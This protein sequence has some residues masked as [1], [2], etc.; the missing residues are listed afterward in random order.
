MKILCS[1]SGVEFTCEHFPGYLSSREYYHPIFSLPQRKL[2]PYLSKW[3]TSELTPTDS[4][5]LFLALLK[6][7]DLVEFRIPAARSALTDSIIASNMEPLA[8]ILTK[9]NAVTNPH[10][11]F[12][13]F[14][15]TQE[16]RFL[17][18]VH[19]WI[20]VWEEAW[21]AFK[22]G[23]RTTLK[24]RSLERREHA[25]EKLIKNPH[26][27]IESYSKHLADWAAT[28]GNF[29]SSLT[30][31][32]KTHIPLST[33]WKDI[34]YTVSTDNGMYSIPLKDLYELL[35]HCEDTI[36]IGTI[37]SNKLFTLLK[38]AI[39]KQEDFLHHRTTDIKETTFSILEETDSIEQAN[40]DAIIQAAPTEEPKRESYPSFIAFMKAREK[41]KLA[42]RYRIG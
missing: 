18:N 31:V 21:K 7:S 5:L 4:Y 37:F 1:L 41:W 34:I 29:P 23:Y 42:C 35:D 22:D 26:K 2:L 24:L 30:L 27:T 14:V 17:L 36:P 19:H 25:L 28:A 11:A 12:P 40:I 10:V 16:T 13:S 32:H 9:L 8:M 20:E 33:Y 39:K 3:S 15:I 6:S 38:T